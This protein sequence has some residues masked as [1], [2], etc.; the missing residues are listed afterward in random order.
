MAGAVTLFFRWIYGLIL[1][2]FEEHGNAWALWHY[3]LARLFPL[4]GIS[5]AGTEAAVMRELGVGNLSSG[6]L[7]AWNT[8]SLLNG[9]LGL[10]ALFLIGLA[11]RNRF[12]IG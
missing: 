3:S 2:P 8:A 1:F 12:K 4:P 11:L 10:L 5:T 7:L 6:W 9:I